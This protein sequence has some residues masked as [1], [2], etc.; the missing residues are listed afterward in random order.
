MILS[1]TKFMIIG[2]SR[3]G[4]DVNVMINRDREY[5]RFFV[6]YKINWKRQIKYVQSKW[7]RS[8]C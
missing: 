4:M 2:N 6:D 3:T 7:S 8:I 5:T 1:K